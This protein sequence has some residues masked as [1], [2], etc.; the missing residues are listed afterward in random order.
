MVHNRKKSVV[1]LYFI[2]LAAVTCIVTIAT[3]RL[4]VEDNAR[5]QARYNLAQIKY[6]YTNTVTQMGVAK[7]L[8]VCTAK[9]KT[10]FTG[11]VY[12]LDAETREFVHD[13]SSDVPKKLVFTQESVGKYFTN[14]ESA[15]AAID[16]IMLG[17]N[18][19]T[20]VRA[21]YFF[22]NKAE[23]LEWRYLP[24]DVKNVNE[25]KL[26]AV[27]GIQSEEAFANFK[28]AE[29]VIIVVTSIFIIILLFLYKLQYNTDFVR[30][31]EYDRE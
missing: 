7:S 10:S 25:L 1:Y 9:V 6:C 16:M 18:S 5:Q 22:N 14:W 21:S 24:D 4:C 11:D 15:Q 31:R 2:L 8:D 26:I 27:Q 23:W 28:A 3:L 12:V 20:G 19:E 17:K 13:N 30:R 29:Y